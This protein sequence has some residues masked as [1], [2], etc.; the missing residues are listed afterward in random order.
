MGT[1]V[2]YQGKSVLRELGKVF[3]L[4]KDEIDELVESRNERIARDHIWKLI[5]TY[6]AYIIERELPANISIHAGGVLI[7]EKPIYAY[8]TTDFPPK[9]LPVSQFEMHNAEDFGIYKFDILSQRGLGHIKEAVKQVKRNRGVEVDV[10]R[11]K[12][13]KEDKKI[14]ELMRHSKAMGCFYVESPA[15]RMLLGKLQCDDYLT[16]VAASSIIRPGVASSGMM[17][18]YIER[19]H[20][21]K[22]G[23]TY[24]AIHPVMDEL[25][26]E[27]YGVM[28]YQE[29]VIRV[30][31]HFGKLTL[32]QADVLRRG[33]SGKYRS[34]EEFQ[35]VREEFFSNC[36]RQ[37]YDQKVIDRVW[38]EIESFAGYSFA[39]GHSA[40]YAVESYQSLYLKAHFPLEFMVGV[41][42]NFG[43][44]YKTEFYFHEARMSG[45]DIQAP[46]VNL[47][48]YLTTIYG[49]RIYVGFIHLKSLETKVAQHIAVERRSNG[50]YKSLD[51]FLRRIELGLEQVRILIRI[52]AFRFTGK[53]KQ[54]LLWS[55][56]LFFSGAKTRNKTTVDLFDTEPKE[57]PLPALQ[58]N[59]QE[60]SYDEMELLGFPIGDPFKLVE[61]PEDG[62]TAATELVGKLGGDVQ[63]LGYCVTTKDTSTKKGEVMHFGTFYDRHGHVFDTVHFPDIAKQYPFRGRGFYNIKGKVVEDFGV[64]MIEVSS[65]FKVPMIHKRPEAAMLTMPV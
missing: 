1:H 26:K 25:M 9:N 57:Y 6:A 19:F 62:D 2:T 44:F 42:N 39:K 51:N 47:S 56:L 65:M 64:F 40:S 15:M 4:P 46:C 37:G 20:I 63:V 29:D 36:T 21:V 10:H 54:E 60:D 33:M 52:G 16:L 22:N 3:G 32:T 45:A 35:Q 34:R 41:I 17:K 8:T 49:N 59:S 53:T 12:D 55:A 11:F 13:F 58:R 18:A 27:T 48:E 23:G 43:G 31:H 28:V 50:P 61:K 5:H 38:Y 24:E 7:T 30:A 14:K